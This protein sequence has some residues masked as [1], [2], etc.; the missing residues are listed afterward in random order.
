MKRREE[1]TFLEQIYVVEVVKGIKI[2]FCL[3]Q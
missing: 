3:K 1:M 2:T